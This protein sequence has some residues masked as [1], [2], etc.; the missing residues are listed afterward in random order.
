MLGTGRNNKLNVKNKF[1]GFDSTFE[2]LIWRFGL[3]LRFG[4]L[5]MELFYLEL[6]FGNW[7]RVNLNEKFDIAKF[8]INKSYCIL[9]F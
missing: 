7:R 6:W 4:A 2:V 1:N 5:L 3:E 9:S 8:I